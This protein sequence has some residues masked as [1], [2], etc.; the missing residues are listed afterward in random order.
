MNV[1]TLRSGRDIPT[2][3]RIAEA[4]E[5]LRQIDIFDPTKIKMP[6]SIV[7]AGGIGSVVA[8]ALAKMGLT[9]LDVYDFD[10]VAHWNIP[11]QMFRPNQIGEFKVDAL[12]EVV[13][14][15]TGVTIFP[16]K[17]KIGDA[18]SQAG[19]GLRRGGIVVSA[20]DSMEA[21]SAIWKEVKMNPKFRLLVDGRLGGESIVLYTVNPCDPE[22]VKTYEAT[23]HP[24]DEGEEL[25]CT[26]RSIIWTTFFIGAFVSRA[27]GKYLKDG[28]ITSE[29]ALDSAFLT[30]YQS[31]DA[32]QP[33]D[34]P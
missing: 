24:D 15:L 3:E 19:V 12:T 20:V 6:V 33:G 1:N 23:L 2:E 26:A 28:T 30:M 10:Q 27:I 14:D 9:E 13:E 22:G 29:V 34:R 5:Y 7:G 31:E 16:L 11:N 17:R 4:G 21:R 8:L 18:T 32:R 25:S